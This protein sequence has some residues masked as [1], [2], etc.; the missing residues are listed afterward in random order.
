MFNLFKS[1]FYFSR[2]EK[3]GILLLLISIGLVVL[4]GQYFTSKRSNDQFSAADLAEQT[5]M[6]QEYEAFTASLQEI[7][8]KASNYSSA[9]SKQKPSEKPSITLAPFNPNKADSLTFRK[10]GL[11]SW[12]TQN[13]L[14]Y[15]QKGGTFRKASDFKK[16]YGLTEEQYSTLLPYINIPPPD[17]MSQSP[18]LYTPP[19]P[20]E[21]FKY[22]AGTTLE[23]NKADTTELK[24]IPGIGSG[25][26]RLIVG[27]RERLGGFY[28]IEQ[29]E[30]IHLNVESLRP[31]FS[32]D[33][34]LIQRIPAN[35]TG[36]ER[37]RAHPY[38]NFYQAKAIV[39][40]RRKKG[41]LTDLKPF[42]LYEEFAPEE[43]EQ[44]ALYLSFE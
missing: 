23:L 37:L 38:L 13:I 14:H 35:R 27:Y 32:I 33:P 21:S 30:E 1:F 6:Q 31:W 15:R 41:N 26:A 40:Y 17:T 20:I 36:V 19:P 11:P 7:D 25:I 18:R 43:L 39:E 10:L 8:R 22:T 24:K 5:R 29:L 34:T 4:V 44:I 2:E 12:M 16:I 28:R 3:R 9:F 42:T